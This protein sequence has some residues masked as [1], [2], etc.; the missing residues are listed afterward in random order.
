MRRPVLL[1]PLELLVLVTLALLAVI[2]TPAKDDEGP[3][4]LAA[5]TAS[6]PGLATETPGLS[7]M[8]KGWDGPPFR[9]MLVLKVPEQ[10]RLTPLLMHCAKACFETPA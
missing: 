9:L 4:L 10:V 6:P 1:S 3:V 2:E 8:L 5:L 7:K